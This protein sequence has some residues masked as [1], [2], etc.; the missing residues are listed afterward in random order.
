MRLPL[1][2]ALLLAASP[3]AA[4]ELTVAA[5]AG[6]DLVMAVNCGYGNWLTP[7]IWNEAFVPPDDRRL[8]AF[9]FAVTPPASDQPLAYRMAIGTLSTRGTWSGDLFS[10]E[11]ETS[12]D[13]REVSA[14]IPGGLMLT[15]GVNYLAYVEPLSPGWNYG[16]TLT[17]IGPGVVGMSILFFTDS[18]MVDLDLPHD[19]D[20]AMHASF[21]Q[22]PEPSILML[23]GVGLFGFMW[24]RRT[25]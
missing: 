22:V 6:G 23:F 2:L 20:V 18:H 11:L 25:R 3:A 14:T 8:D 12:S 15:P 9:S 16:T 4:S 5:V 1:A 21:S 10:A 17:N 13:A 7:S 24:R 19:R